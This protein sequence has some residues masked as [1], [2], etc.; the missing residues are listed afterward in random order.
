MTCMHRKVLL[1]HHCC[2]IEVKWDTNTNY[3]SCS[4]PCLLGVHVY[5]SV[6]C[7]YKA[8]TGKLTVAQGMENHT[9][10]KRTSRAYEST[11]HCVAVSTGTG[12][13]TCTCA[14]AGWVG[15]MVVGIYIHLVCNISIPD[16]QLMQYSAIEITEENVK[17]WWHNLLSITPLAV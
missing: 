11:K 12:L 15:I 14:C 8:Y 13:H 1:I 3:R 4:N 9:K 10:Y 17:V 6:K 16:C 5:H 2:L 7:V